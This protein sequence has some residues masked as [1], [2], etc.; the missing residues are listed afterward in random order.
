M[1]VNTV[2]E[3][4]LYLKG[5]L[6]GDVRS[7]A[8]NLNW[9]KCRTKIGVDEINFTLNDVLFNKWCEER[10]T[11]INDMLR[12][13]ALECR[14]VRNGTPVVGG[15]LATMPAYSP[16]GTSANLAMRFD[17]Y[18]NLLAGVHIYNT[19][20]G[21]PLGTVTGN[22]GTLISGYISDANSRSAAAG[23]GFGFTAGSIDPLASIV[24]TFNTFK[25]IKSFITDRCDN[26]TGAGKF[27]IYF[28]P[29]KTYD[30]IADDDFGDVITDWVAR[31]PA[32]IN[33]DSAMEISA[34]EVSGFASAVIAIGNGELS[35]DSEVNTAIID[36]QQSAAAAGE[37][38]YCET[39]FQ[40]S[41][42]S[43]PQVLQIRALTTLNNVM[44][45]TWRP[46]VVLNG[47]QISPVP[48]GD[49]KIW[50]GDT[51]TVQNDEDLTGMTSGKFR[52]DALEVAV[53]ASNAET[54]TPTLDNEDLV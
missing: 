28:H 32:N 1:I 52:V 17:G 35:A 39:I 9:K 47:R 46:N 41:S 44:A 49:K 53:S 30:I 36:F 3:V 45:P 24:N 38:G 11:S 27:D 29:D 5:T 26:T 51:I 13:Y 21:L 48:T 22:L 42:I 4:N 15:F 34:P 16:R 37:Y 8:E 40:D 18:M 10:Q 20:T 43:S 14:I 50:V 19:G 23:A 33:V 25:T 6:I 7:L 12:P 31:Y 2:Y 54:I